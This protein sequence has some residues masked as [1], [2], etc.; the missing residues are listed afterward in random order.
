VPL[1]PHPRFRLYHSGR[2]YRFVLRDLV[3]GRITRGDDTARLERSVREFVGSRNAICMP[4][5]RIGIYLTLRALGCAGKKVILSPYTIHDVINMVICAGATPVFVDIERETCNVDADRIEELIDG[6]VGAVM[7]THLHGLACDVERIRE[8]CARHDV[9]LLEDSAQAFGC[10][11]G[12][13]S[14]G[15]FGK[16]GIFSFGMAKNVNS[17]YGGMVVTDDD[18]LAGSIREELREWPFQT[19][20]LLL[21]RI[22]FCATG[23]LLTLPPV[24]GLLTFQVFR[25]GQLH[26]IDAITNRWRGE[27]DPKIKRQLPETWKRRMTPMQARLLVPQVGAVDE[28]SRVRIGYAR[29]YHRGLA[30]IPGII[31]PPLREDGS[32]VYLTFP[33]QVPDRMDLL[34]Y[35]TRHGRDLAIQHLANNSAA[36]C[37][38][39]YARACPMAAATAPQVLLLPTY[40]SYGEGQV[41]RNIAL[42]RRYFEAT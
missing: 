32:H 40:P 29:I 5:A 41:A 19:S 36:P 10:R 33:I 35:L 8:I 6:D 42:V 21:H 20:K 15:T 11:V 30:G 14:V 1:A 17:F 7:I 24:Y 12:G 26:N 9:P 13:K 2:N 39:E 4:Q 27:D 38:R 37:F 16:A 31:L 22:L 23:D 18:A 34:N 28:E 3:T 25:Y